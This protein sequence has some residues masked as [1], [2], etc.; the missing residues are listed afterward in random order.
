VIDRLLGFYDKRQARLRALLD[1]GPAT[2]WEL[3]R[4]LF[5]AARPVDAFLTMSETVGTLEALEARGAAARDLV[6][7]VYRFR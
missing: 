5:P 3:S 6:D 4:A 2:A 7:G 1:A